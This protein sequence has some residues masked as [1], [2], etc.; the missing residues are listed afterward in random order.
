MIN[1]YLHDLNYEYSL[2]PDDY[3]KNEIKAG[4]FI[5][6]Y[7]FFLIALIRNCFKIQIVSHP[8]FLIPIVLMRKF[9]KSIVIYYPFEIYGQQSTNKDFYGRLMAKLWFLI[10]IKTINSCDLLIS[11]NKMRIDYY[12]KKY[13]YCG[14]VLELQ[15]TKRNSSL[16]VIRTI[17][18]HIG[19]IY[20]GLITEGRFVKELVQSLKYLPSHYTIYLFGKSEIDE[21]FLSENIKQYGERLKFY[22]E[23]GAE[24]RIILSENI[25]IGFLAYENSCLNNIYSASSKIFDYLEN[26]L[27]I[28]SNDNQGIKYLV[29][30][31]LLEIFDVESRDLGKNIAETLIKAHEKF[32]LKKTTS[33][34]SILKDNSFKSNVQKFQTEIESLSPIYHLRK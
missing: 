30:N 19:I 9:T 28:C 8:V 33:F 14:K 24:E 17:P 11:Q 34:N 15:N 16:K 29:P 6:S 5:R 20:A 2:F 23:F 21:N 7:I 12:V 1:S 13:S 25:Q 22:G 4:N 31:E 26:E 3:I 18:N 27:I 10:E 32:E